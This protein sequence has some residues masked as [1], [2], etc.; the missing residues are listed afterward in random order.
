MKFLQKRRAR[1]AVLADVAQM[2]H[3]EAAWLMRACAREG[4]GEQKLL[5]ALS[6]RALATAPPELRGLYERW[7][8]VYRAGRR[9]KIGTYPATMLEPVDAELSRAVDQAFEEGEQ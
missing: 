8:A 6:Q 9:V 5:V 2:P 7:A 3:A 4:V 1:R